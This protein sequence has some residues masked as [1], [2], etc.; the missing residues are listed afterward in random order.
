MDVKGSKAQGGNEDDAMLFD[1]IAREQRKRKKGSEKVQR[2]GPTETA[3][4]EAP[5]RPAGDTGSRGSLSGWF[6]FWLVGSRSG[7]LVHSTPKAFPDYWA[8]TVHMC[9]TTFS[10]YICV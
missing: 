4:S 9:D 10:W 7:Q 2:K 3:F 6:W 5:F 8:L 1:R